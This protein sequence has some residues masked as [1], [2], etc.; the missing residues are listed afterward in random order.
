MLARDQSRAPTVT[1]WFWIPYTLGN[2]IC[3]PTKNS[4][5]DVSEMHKVTSPAKSDHLQRWCFFGSQ[6]HYT[7]NKSGQ[8]N[9]VIEILT[10]TFE[11]MK[12]WTSTSEECSSTQSWKIKLAATHPTKMEKSEVGSGL[13]CVLWKPTSPQQSPLPISGVS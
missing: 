2:D 5:T 8:C 4:A 1:L 9:R 13:E 12:Q 10:F 7:N 6:E 3:S 11:R